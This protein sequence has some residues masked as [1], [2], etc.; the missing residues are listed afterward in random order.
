MKRF[1]IFLL[2]NSFLLSAIGADEPRYRSCFYSKNHQYKLLLING[3]KS[4]FTDDQTSETWALI[5]TITGKTLYELYSQFSGFSVFVS[6]N[7]KNIIVIDD[8]AVSLKNA[9]VLSFFLNGN[10]IRNYELGFLLKDKNNISLS[11]SHYSWLFNEKTGIENNIFTIKTYELRTFEFSISTGEIIK[12]TID[13]I[14]RGNT[15]YAYGIINKVAEDKY[16]FDIQQLVYGNPFEKVLYIEY[17]NKKEFYK[18]QYVTLIIEN[19]KVLRLYEY[20]QFNLCTYN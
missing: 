4:L 19:G 6:D 12:N 2:I 5:D 10:L 17:D 15:I 7:G 13:P 9:V 11:A 3:E 1:I 16:S 18:N 20:L 8:Y 14:I